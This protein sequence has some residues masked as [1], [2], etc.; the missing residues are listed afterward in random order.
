MKE[1]ATLLID[2]GTCRDAE[3]FQHLFRDITDARNLVEGKD[4]K[5][6]VRSGAF[7]NTLFAS[8][9]GNIIDTGIINVYIIFSFG[10]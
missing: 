10:T 9:K 2:I 7:S 1:K 5:S 8:Y 6:K 4:E 3:R